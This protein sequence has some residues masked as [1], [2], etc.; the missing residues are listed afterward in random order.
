M[1]DDDWT[2]DFGSLD[3][4]RSA[5]GGEAPG[6]DRGARRLQRRRRLPAGSRPATTWRGAR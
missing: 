6:A 2:P 3:C 4:G 5:L 1:A